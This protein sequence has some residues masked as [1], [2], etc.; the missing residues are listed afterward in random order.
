MSI[1]HL[2]KTDRQKKWVLELSET[3]VIRNGKIVWKHGSYCLYFCLKLKFLGWPYRKYIKTAKMAAYNEDLLCRDDF[4]AALAFF[5]SYCYSVNTSE[6]VEKIATDEKDYHKCSL[7]SLCKISLYV[8]D[9]IKTTPWKLRIL[10][11]NNSRV[12]YLLFNI[13]YC[14][15]KFVNKHIIYLEWA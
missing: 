6:A 14:F 11:P 10:N 8:W 3:I 15:C 13:V 12:I 5:L 2:D 4:D 9:H 7:C 1:L